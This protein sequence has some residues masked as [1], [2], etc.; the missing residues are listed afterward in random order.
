MIVIYYAMNSWIYEIEISLQ[1]LLCLC[2][3]T[4]GSNTNFYVANLTGDSTLCR[5]T[6][7]SNGK[8]KTP[9]VIPSIVNLYRLVNRVFSVFV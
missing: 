5:T 7:K 6:P 1:Y 2:D 9:I 4:A 3:G 8:F